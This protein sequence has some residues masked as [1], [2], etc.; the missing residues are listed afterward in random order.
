VRDLYWNV[1]A[2]HP[3]TAALHESR[4]GGGRPA[5]QRTKQ[6]LHGGTHPPLPFLSAPEP[7]THPSPRRMHSPHTHTAL[8]SMASTEGSFEQGPAGSLPPAIIAQFL[9][10]QQGDGAPTATSQQ[11]QQ[12]RRGGVSKWLRRILVTGAAAGLVAGGAILGK[13]L[14]A[15]YMVGGKGFDGGRNGSLHATCR[16]PRSQPPHPDPPTRPTPPPRPTFQSTLDDR[17]ALQR[18]VD[19]LGRQLERATSRAATA[20]AA[21]SLQ[22][23]ALEGATARG[24]ALAAEAQE[25]ARLNRALQL[26]L[27]KTEAKADKAAAARADA[28]A[29]A[30]AA[31]A[32]AAA[33]S[34]AAARWE[35]EAAAAAE[36]L[37][38]AEARLAAATK[39]NAALRAGRT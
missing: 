33:A 18:S 38:Q 20:D 13:E 39:A 14:H 28:E 17:D 11:Q 37:Q 2:K 30:A 29:R 32:E 12:P 31:R 23:E 22:R 4:T 34:E 26:R 5:A 1:A 27:E 16:R 9:A 8:Q 3:P 7:R 6:R 15:N 10:Q 21:F 25:V 24:A 35:R 36:R 19:A